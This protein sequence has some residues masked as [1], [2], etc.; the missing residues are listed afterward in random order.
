[1]S[2][3]MLTKYYPK[4]IYQNILISESIFKD[5]LNWNNLKMYFRYFKLDLHSFFND[6]LIKLNLRN[7]E[8]HQY[9][10]VLKFKSSHLDLINSEGSFPKKYRFMSIFCHV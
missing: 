2:F 8:L 4:E 3:K 9:F 10:T 1:M 7:P 6:Q 5:I